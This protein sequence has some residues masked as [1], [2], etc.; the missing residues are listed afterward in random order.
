MKIIATRDEKRNQSQKINPSRPR[1]NFK[2]AAAPPPLNLSYA[3]TVRNNLPM[4][5]S[6]NNEH[7]NLINNNSNYMFD[8][9]NAEASQLFGCSFAALDEKFTKYLLLLEKAANPSE[10]RL[11]LLNFLSD[12]KNYG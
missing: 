7:I 5:T 11:A 8:L 12:T 4:N 3:N 2:A 9:L 10:R 1:G 6:R